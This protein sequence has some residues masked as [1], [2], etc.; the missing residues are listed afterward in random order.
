MNHDSTLVEL[1][2]GCGQI[3]DTVKVEWGESWSEWDQSVRDAISGQL[4]RIYARCTCEGVP[5]PVHGHSAD[6]QE[7]RCSDAAAEARNK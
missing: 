5:C 1:L 7:P 6:I 4:Q 2:T 3:L